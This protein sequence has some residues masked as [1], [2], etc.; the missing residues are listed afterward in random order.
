VRLVGPHAAQFSLPEGA[1]EG[2]LAR[3]LVARA[4]ELGD[5]RAL[6][7]RDLTF[8]APTRV[9]PIEEA[10]LEGQALLRVLFEPRVA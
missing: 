5:L 6:T 10:P 9:H 3:L 1:H 7:A 4:R 8:D 2:G